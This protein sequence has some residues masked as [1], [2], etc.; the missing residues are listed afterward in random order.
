MPYFNTDQ[1]CGIEKLDAYLKKIDLG[2]SPYQ[3]P[4]PCPWLR[5]LPEELVTEV[6][7]RK[8]RHIKGT[9]YCTEQKGPCHVKGRLMVVKPR[10]DGSPLIGIECAAGHQLVVGIE[11]FLPVRRPEDAYRRDE[12]DNLT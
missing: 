8:E 12:K 11:S 4:F 6:I 10:E 2:P 9:L 7:G 3:K 1:S 5:M